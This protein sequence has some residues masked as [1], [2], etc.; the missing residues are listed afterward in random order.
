MQETEASTSSQDLGTATTSLTGVISSFVGN[1]QNLNANNCTLPEISAYGFSLG[2]MNLCT[3]SP[4]NWVAGITN[5][6][7]SLITLGLAYHLFK[8]IMGIAKSLAGGK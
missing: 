5:V 1:L 4:P 3:F 2:Q 6:V 8:R 7:V